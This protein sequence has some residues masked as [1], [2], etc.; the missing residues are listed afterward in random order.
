M[1]HYLHLAPIAIT[2]IIAATLI[3]ERVIALF[4]RFTLDGKA[5]L[6]QVEGLIGKGNLQGAIDLCASNEKKLLPRVVKAGLLKATRD[7]DEIKNAF[8]VLLIDCSSLV[9]QR[10]GY[11]AMIA[12]VAT[13]LGLLGTIAGLIS[14]FEAVA[15]ADAATKQSL[16]ASGISM[17]MNATAL[18]LIVAIPVMVAYSVLNGK[19]NRI[20]DELEKAAGRTMGLLHGRLYVDQDEDFSKI[21]FDQVEKG[22]EKSEKSEKVVKLKG[23]A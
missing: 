20:M 21:A 23:A 13:L 1:S 19:A 16:L 17:S 22:G 9:T 3:W 5:F 12:N 10:I 18:G 14:S 7:E 15:S 6:A 4:F 2:G 11:L 8:E